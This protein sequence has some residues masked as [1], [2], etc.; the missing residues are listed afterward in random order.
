MAAARRSTTAQRARLLAHVDRPKS[1][2]RVREPR[3]LP[4]GL[5]RAETA[6]LL[7][8]VRTDRGRAI[9]G[10]MLFS[11]LRSAE[12]L[13]LQVRDVDIPDVGSG[14]WATAT[15]NAGC[16]WMSTSQGRCN[17]PV[18][19]ATR[20]SEHHIVHGGQGFSSWTT[21]DTVQALPGR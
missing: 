2:L 17:V 10:L 14:S 16:R 9:A 21:A 15:R 7:G 11:G 19:R 1:R 18:G 20:I 13:G 5:D 6:A 8:S 3:R 12:V 4:R